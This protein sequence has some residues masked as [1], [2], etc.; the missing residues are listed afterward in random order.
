[1]RRGEWA[2][3]PHVPLGNELLLCKRTQE[4]LREET[5]PAGIQKRTSYSHCHRSCPFGCEWR[6]ATFPSTSTSG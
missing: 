3:A 4:D 5:A 6:G 1:M 2:A